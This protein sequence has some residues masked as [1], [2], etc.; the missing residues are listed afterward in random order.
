MAEGLS[1]DS[2][3]LSAPEAPLVSEGP[4]FSVQPSSFSVSDASLVTGHA[5][6]A[7]GVGR[8]ELVF[9]E[10]SIQDPEQLAA[11]IRPEAE[12][13]W[14]DD[15]RDGIEQVS[16]ALA[17]RHD[18]DAIHFVTHGS[19][20]QVKLGNAWL[21]QE[22]LAGYADQ[23]ASWQ[24]ALTPEADL[25]FYACDLGGSAEGQSLLESIHQ[26]TGADIA[27]STNNTGHVQYGADWTLEYRLG[28]I[29][30]G[31]VL[32]RSVE[33][34]WAGLLATVTVTNKNDVVNGDTGSIALLIANTGG[35][36]IS[37]REAILAANNTAG[38]DTI[39]FNIGAQTEGSDGT[40][41]DTNWTATK[42]QDTTAGQSA[43]FTAAQQASGGNPGQFR[44]VS[45]T[46]NTGTI[47]VA[48]VRSSA[49]YSPQTEGA[50]ASVSFSYDLISNGQATTYRPLILQDSTYYVGPSNSISST[51]WTGFTQSALQ[52]SSFSKLSGSGPS[53]PN[54]FSGGR[55]MQFGYATQN[56]SAS[57]SITRISGIDNWSVSVTQ[58]VKTISPQ[59]AL[60]VI[61]SPV[62]I[63][64][65]TQPGASVNTMSLS[66][67]DNAVLAIELN[68]TDAGAGTIGLEV[69]SSGSGSTIRGLAINGFKSSGIWL[70][71]GSSQNTITGNFIGTDPT[72][73]IDRGNAG[74]GITI[75][76]S[77]NNTI[78]G[79]TVA[80][81][82]VISGNGTDGFEIAFAGSTGNMIQGNYIG[83][84]A[85]GTAALPN[86]ADGIR[87]TTSAN[88]NTIGVTPTGVGLGNVIS[89]NGSVGVEV[90]QSTGNSIGGNFLGTNAAG[91]AAVPNASVGVYVLDSTNTTIGGTGGITTRNIISGNTFHGIQLNGTTTGTLVQ[92]NYI[93]LDVNGTTSIG[94]QDTGVM[95]KN[96][97]T[98]N[99]IGGGLAF[100]NVIS[101][102]NQDGIQLYGDVAGV[103]ENA[104]LGNYIG[105]D[106]TGTVDLG[107]G[108]FGVGIFGS[109]T[110][111][112]IGGGVGN[113]ISGN[114]QG[115]VYLDGAA[116]TGNVIRGNYI[117]LAQNG[118][119]PLGNT[120]HGVRIG[121]SNNTIGGTVNFQQPVSPNIIA[122]NSLAGIVV[123]SGT[124]NTL[125]TNWIYSN[126]GLGIDLSDNGVTP[127]DPG[128]G[129]G[130]T[131]PNNLQNYPVLTSAYATGFALD[132]TLGGTSA[133]VTGVLSGV[134]SDKIRL[135]A[136]VNPPSDPNEGKLLMHTGFDYDPAVYGS[137]GI[138]ILTFPAVTVGDYV[139]VIA[140]RLSTG[141][142][143]EF[144]APIVA[145]SAPPALDLNGSS[146]GLDF[147]RTWTEDGGPV[148]VAD[149][150]ATITDQDSA[151]LQSLTATITNRQN[152]TAEVLDA[153]T[154][155]G[156][157]KNYD[158]ATGVLTLSGSATVAT[159]QQV[160]RTGGCAR[161]S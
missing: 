7:E 118:T 71:G 145:A 157:T 133:K 112:T 33:D 18:L 83:V 107:N 124:G 100:R 81:R 144:S 141:D 19:E 125:E 28:T 48:H 55:S 10:S 95:I 59:S 126:G 159:Y 34:T 5:S 43:T 150:D 151:N 63:D 86:D 24:S 88:S 80:L 62:I 131:G 12:V 6:R 45:Q 64:G 140:T 35:D 98:K 160:L 152:G 66:A 13:I 58:S 65:Y 39:S 138:F 31:P 16:T 109:A 61:T 149:T 82:N 121:A 85:A 21:L 137:S 139:T 134:G 108:Q 117:G 30:T 49:N 40:F 101:G 44:G 94:I 74:D 147:T 148:I 1:A 79:T 135:Q 14:L 20:R 42:I 103:S 32:S 27:A 37:L 38:L 78:G 56:T 8:R 119:D 22:T 69:V 116:T 52:A 75:A 23:I 120:G 106:F 53:T 158:S 9:I 122:Y 2:L 97:P 99:T 68:G 54:F 25:L 115:G 143:S 51:S 105:T 128:G 57:G 17:E 132:G 146:T 47:T 110:N 60:P 113:V 153:T 4:A 29:E 96:G 102:N 91:D 155:G 73:M 154:S 11:G 129:D 111:N 77:S 89:G 123:V 104:V 87:L 156:I 36:G 67:G 41:T 70:D 90:Y 130:D 127:N 114:Q 93:G 76:G 46:V 72:G 26:L 84:N 50:L 136:F 92:G 15:A 161:I 3:Q 142:T